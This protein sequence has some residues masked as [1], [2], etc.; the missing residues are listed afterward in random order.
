MVA[1]QAAPRP[2]KGYPATHPGQVVR[3][4]NS[5]NTNDTISEIIRGSIGGTTV[6]SSEA[7]PVVFQYSLNIK[8][9]NS[10]SGDQAEFSTT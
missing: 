7:F 5:N 2:S 6:T 9:S 10:N 3:G 8:V 1:N 4:H